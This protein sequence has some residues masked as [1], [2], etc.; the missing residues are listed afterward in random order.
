MMLQ[1]QLEFLGSVIRVG[2]TAALQ[3]ARPD[4]PVTDA[5]EVPAW[6]TS[7]RRNG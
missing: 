2:A 3:K 5:A 7:S 1:D 4:R 6:C